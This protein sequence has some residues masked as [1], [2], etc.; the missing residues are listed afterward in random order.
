MDCFDKKVQIA[1]MPKASYVSGARPHHPC[2]ISS[3]LYRKRKAGFS[4]ISS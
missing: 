3:L 4:E 2:V 1:N